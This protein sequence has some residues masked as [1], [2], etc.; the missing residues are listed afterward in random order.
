MCMDLNTLALYHSSLWNRNEVLT[1][2]GHAGSH[3]QAWWGNAYYDLWNL[4]SVA[5]D[6]CRFGYQW[7]TCQLVCI[8]M[9]G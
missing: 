7:N 9:T 5:H 2:W 8:E 3:H 6:G 4:C 1:V